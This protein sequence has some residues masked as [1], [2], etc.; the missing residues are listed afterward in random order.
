MA[1]PCSMRGGPDT[2]APVPESLPETYR[3]VFQNA[4]NGTVAPVVLVTVLVNGEHPGSRGGVDAAVL[5]VVEHGRLVVREPDADRARRI[6]AADCCDE[7]RAGDDLPVGAGGVCRSGGGRNDQEED[8]G[9][10]RRASN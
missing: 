10:D 2:S 9:D 3:S 6:G 4:L 8:R 7:L 1:I 5:V